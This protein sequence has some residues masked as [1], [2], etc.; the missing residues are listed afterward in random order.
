MP[1]RDIKLC[2]KI[3]Q[4]FWLALEDLY[5]RKY[6]D[7]KLILTCTYRSPEEQYQ[8]Y[9]KGRTLPGKKVTNCDGYKCLSAHNYKP[10]RAF[11]VAVYD[12][13]TKKIRWEHR[14]YSKLGEMRTILGYY[15][16]I[17]WGGEFKTFKDYPH[18]GLRKIVYVWEN[19]GI[20]KYVS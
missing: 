14:Y 9:Q 5:K 11:D 19:K 6:P 8:L 7:R 13:K 18:F 15:K 20:H 16:T 10:S 12:L 2:T 4:D 1:S 17:Y 3:L